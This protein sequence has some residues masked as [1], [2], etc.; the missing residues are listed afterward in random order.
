MRPANAPDL[1]ISGAL[2]ETWLERRP[3]PLL[4]TLLVTKTSKLLNAWTWEFCDLNPGLE[5]CLRERLTEH[6]TIELFVRARRDERVWG[7]PYWSSV[8]PVRI[9]ERWENLASG[10]LDP[11]AVLLNPCLCLQALI[12]RELFAP[13]ALW[14]DEVLSPAKWLLFYGSAHASAAELHPGP[15]A[16]T[17]DDLVEAVCLRGAAG[18]PPP[19]PTLRSR[20]ARNRLRLKHP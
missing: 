9:G 8:H 12:E 1:P 2:F 11:D 5:L 15:A 3:T 7:L 13:F 19:F 18:A 14:V 6:W 4:E 17:R 16:L 20:L 10:E